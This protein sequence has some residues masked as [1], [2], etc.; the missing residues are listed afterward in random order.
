MKPLPFC[1]SSLRQ[2]SA[3]L[4]NCNVHVWRLQFQLFNL[5]AIERQQ[6]SGQ[7]GTLCAGNKISTRAL[8]F[9]L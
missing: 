6:V 8:M 4:G 7:Q 5:P 1:L 2:I 3:T 9:I